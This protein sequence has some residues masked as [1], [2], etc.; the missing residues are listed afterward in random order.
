MS[1]DI[2]IE[3]EVEQSFLEEVRSIH[4]DVMRF[5]PP[6]E[7]SWLEINI[8]Y[9]KRRILS[10]AQSP[11]CNAKIGCRISYINLLPSKKEYSKE[12]IDQ[13]Y[14]LIAH[15]TDLGFTIMNYSNKDW[16]MFDI[17]W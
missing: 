12:D 3:K 13:I 6:K 7:A 9:V 4:K 1:D 5:N 11:K 16:Y 10:A 15:F 14:K 17:D 2:E 8:A